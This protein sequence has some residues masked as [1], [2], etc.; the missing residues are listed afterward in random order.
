M[1]E[2]T[3]WSTLAEGYSE[4]IYDQFDSQLVDHELAD[5]VAT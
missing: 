4:G 3:N 2:Q 5:S 1:M